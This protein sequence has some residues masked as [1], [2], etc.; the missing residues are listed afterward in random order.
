M[1]GGGCSV[2]AIWILTPHDAVA[3][4]RRFAVVEKRWRVAWEAEG[5]ARAEMMPLPA[6]YEVAAAFAER[7]RR[8]GTARG[9]GIRTSMSSAGSDSWVDDPITRHI[10]SLHIDKEEGEGFML[11]PVVLQKRGSYYIL[12]LPLVD[13]QSF[14][15]YESLL[16]RSD[17]G[18]SAKEKGN[19]SSI[20]LNLPC[21]TGALMVA[22]VIGD[23][24]TGDTAEP[25][26]IVSTGPSVGGLLDSLTGS[27]GI[28]ARPKPI[29]APVAAPT[30]SISSPV[31]APQ[32]ES[33]KGGMRPFDKD[34]LRNFILGA[35][36]FGT[37]QDLNYANVTSVRTT[38]FSADPL[39][40][41]QKQP[42]WKPYLYKGRQRTLFSSLETLNAALYD[43]DD[44]QDFLSVSGQVTCRA[45]LEGLP[46]VSLP[47]SGLK[48][49]RVEVSSFHHCVQASE[50]TNDKQTLI[51]QPPLGNFVLMHYQASCNMDPPVKGFYQLSMVSENEGAFLFKLR[52][53]EGYKS[54]FLME[55]CMVT[56]PF[57]RRRVASY[58]GNPSVGTVSMTEHSIEWRIVS[59]GRGLSGRSIEA[60]F[61]GTVRF[62]P[63]TIQRVN[64]SFRSVPSTAFVEDSDSEQDNTKNGANLDDYLMEKMNKD[65]QAVNLEE[66]L[67]WQAYN[68]AKVSFKI[69][70]GT[71]SGLTIDPKSVTIYPSVK[72]PVEYSMQASSGDYILWN[73]LG[74]C[75]SAALPK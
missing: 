26:V 33:L 53:M 69:V 6:D 51:F 45:E 55:F 11:W 23:I 70:G 62:H 4:S 64:S 25:E 42:A 30:A 41:D 36:P 50:P 20:L 14:K 28:S 40:T 65:L 34:L 3:F 32:S 44:V 17:C 38:G 59:S 19:L 16:K 67:S 31:G 12:V 46:D 74:K 22:H 73:T 56:M 8:E 15:A 18:S 57:P 71:L 52:L 10:I 60:T 9:S 63:I 7:R 35:M 58:D 54:P 48:A 21:I 2:R 39:P 61:S 66:P 72:A 68:Y 5:G 1:S 37:P 24:I 43:R 13:P 47:L 29:A 75:P 49:A 27:I